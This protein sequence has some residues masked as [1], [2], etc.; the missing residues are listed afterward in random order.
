MSKEK[1]ILALYLP[2][3]HK[4]KENDEWWG[5]NY[6]EWSAVKSA[7]PL[8]K[9]HIQPVEPLNDNY[10]NLSDETGKVW[11]WQAKLA[12]KYNVYGFCIYHYWFDSEHQLLEKPMEILLSH[13]EIDINYCICWAN[14]TWTRT[15]YG[16]ESEILMEQ[17]YGN[18]EEWEK[19]FKYLLP[20]F[21]DKRYIKID[22]KP[23]INIYRTYDINEFESMMRL[24]NLLAIEN[25]FDGIYIVSGNT[26]GKIENREELVDA[27][28]NFEPGFT[29]KHKLSFFETKRYES[30]VFIRTLYNKM[31]KKN[32]LERKL[33]INIVYKN[34]FNTPLSQTKPV[35]LGI[36]P[37]WD[38]T[39]R[40]GNKGFIYYNASPDN[41]KK[42]LSLTLKN[43][44]SEFIYINAWNEWGEG[45]FLEPDK[46]DKYGYL[47]AIKEVIL[48]SQQQIYIE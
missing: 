4:V 46:N 34:L 41:F 11:E 6:T 38:N 21:L 48:D 8:Y 37:K 23:M 44:E 20:F 24:W 17:K 2:Q 9:G 14:E 18:K 16:K 3:Y 47:N 27:F 7:R 19:H 29:L 22:N 10:Y 30:S 32:I 1:K 25:G 42:V 40:R 13:K 5:E 43:S 12:R 36:M 31:F 39:P 15:W 35:Y 33:D 45:A 28:Y 26:N